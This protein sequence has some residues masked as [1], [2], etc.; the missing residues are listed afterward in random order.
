MFLAQVWAVIVSIWKWMWA[1]KKIAV[2][3]I[4]VGIIA[5]L[6]WKNKSLTQKNTILTEERGKLPDNIEFIASLKDTDFKVTYRDSKNNVIVK[7]YYVP[8]EGG[9]SFTKYIDLKQYDPKAG[10]TGQSINPPT[11]NPISGILATIL[12]P[13]KPKDANNSNNP[14]AID[15]YGF[16]FKPGMQGLYTSSLDKPFDVGLDL[17]LLYI[18]R[19]SAG[20]GST[21]YAP[22]VWMSYHVDQFVPFF[23][24]ENVEGVVGL[25]K[26]Y[27]DFSK[28][29][30][31]IGIRSNL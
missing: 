25:S 3:I 18:N 30:L 24:L 7:E 1:N 27:D 10:F 26:P 19:F 9:V 20:I 17:K 23:K 31:S 29:A 2:Y 5:L 6:T 4:L 22:N 28:N 11:T 21:L 13:F 8:R 15:W 14:I 12:N 16:T